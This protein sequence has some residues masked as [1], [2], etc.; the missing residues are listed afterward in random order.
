[1]SL[2]KLTKLSPVV[3]LIGFDL[4]CTGLSLLLARFVQLGAGLWRF[5]LETKKF[6]RIENFIMS[7]K[8]PV[9]MEAK[10]IQLTGITQEF[11]DK[12]VYTAR[13]VLER[14]EQF[15]TEHCEDQV[16]RLLVGYNTHTYDLP[17]II[18]EAERSGLDAEKYFQSL[19]L[20][21]T[22][23]LYPIC[24][25]V[26]ETTKL[27]RKANGRPSYKLGSVYRALLDRPLKDAHNALVDALG[28]L[29][30]LEIGCLEH[31]S[32]LEPYLYAA[33]MEKPESMKKNGIRETLKLVNSYLLGLVDQKINLKTFGL[34]PALEIGN[35]KKRIASEVN[36]FAILKK[37]SKEQKDKRLPALEPF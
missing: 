30:V 8:S 17:F 12:Q 16:P 10:S 15:L 7:C 11:V 33:M 35:V 18:G 14:F 13:D 3:Y 32:F 6:E 9:P 1:M 29:D 2:A 5:T 21:A 26:M 4:E 24:Q 36:C 20:T 37:I 22:I 31:K 28:V 23:D 34:L 27:D 25:E 19:K